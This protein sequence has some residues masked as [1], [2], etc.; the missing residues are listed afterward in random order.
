ML[1]NKGITAT[2]FS[3]KFSELKEK[4]SSIEK[5]SL[6]LGYYKDLEAY[7]DRLYE[8][9]VVAENFDEERFDEIREAEMSNLNRLQKLKNSHSYKKA[10]HKRNVE[11]WE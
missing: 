7:I 2:A 5:S 11:D 6:D 10:K 8:Q 4:L 9:T 1:R 3:K